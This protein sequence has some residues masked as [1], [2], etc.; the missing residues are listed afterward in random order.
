MAV[1]I[2]RLKQEMVRFELQNV[3]LIAATKQNVVKD[4]EL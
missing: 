4:D 2:N 3:I 1:F